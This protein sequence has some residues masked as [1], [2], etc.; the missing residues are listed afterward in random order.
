MKKTLF[1]YFSFKL[2]IN[3]GEIKNKT[4]YLQRKMNYYWEIFVTFSI[5]RGPYIIAI[6]SL[7][8]Y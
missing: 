1:L 8:K 2:I 3:K 4:F 5:K 6:A 7:K